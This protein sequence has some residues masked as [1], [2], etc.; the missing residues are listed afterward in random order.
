VKDI[1]KDDQIYK[2][3]RCF[4]RCLTATIHICITELFQGK[5]KEKGDNRIIF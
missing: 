3:F 2:E 4:D 5:E 1:H